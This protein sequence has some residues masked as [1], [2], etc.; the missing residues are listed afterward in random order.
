MAVPK[1]P[2]HPLPVHFSLRLGALEAEHVSRLSAIRSDFI[3][4]AAEA[5]SAGSV[6]AALDANGGWPA[7][8]H[9]RFVS[10]LTSIPFYRYS[11]RQNSYAVLEESHDWLRRGPR[12]YFP[13]SLFLLKDNNQI[14]D[15]TSPHWRRDFRGLKTVV[16][17]YIE[18]FFSF[19]FTFA[20]I[21]GLVVHH[22]RLPDN[23]ILVPALSC[24]P[25]KENII[26]NSYRTTVVAPPHSTVLFLGRGQHD[27]MAR[28]MK[29]IKAAK[30]AAT[31]V[32]GGVSGGS[33]D[34]SATVTKRLNSDLPGV[35]PAEISRHESWYRRRGLHLAKKRAEKQVGHAFVRT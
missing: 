27:M 1:A 12:R 15:G 28:F 20:L 21:R 24:A 23:S 4:D 16:H 35:S 7:D 2:R 10:I 34:S 3:R 8:Q 33:S 5:T 19:F 31:G 26:S 13:R 25:K 18:V 17:S 22:N 11:R 6:E 29:V 14:K 30:G 32:A 9:F